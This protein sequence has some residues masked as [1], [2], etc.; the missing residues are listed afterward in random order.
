[1]PGGRAYPPCYGPRMANP[2]A[3]PIAAPPKRRRWPWVAAGCGCITMLAAFV[4]F[5][6][7]WQVL[8]PSE[9]AEQR[10]RERHAEAGAATR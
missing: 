10:W 8:Q 9:K 4:A 6:A 2:Y 1:V 7:V 5:L 3:A